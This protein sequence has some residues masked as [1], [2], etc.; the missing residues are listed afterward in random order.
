[1]QNYTPTPAPLPA[2]I[3][4]PQDAFDDVVVSTLRTSTEPIADAVAF[5]QA[6]RICFAYM[7]EAMSPVANDDPMPIALSASFPSGAWAIATNQITVPVTGVYRVSLKCEATNG[8][9]GVNAIANF[10]IMVGAAGEVAW[11]TGD[12]YTAA[13]TDPFLAIGQGTVVITD[14]AAHYIWVKNTSGNYANVSGDG[15]S[16]DAMI[17]PL[18]IEYVG[19][20]T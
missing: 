19:E 6:A 2:T 3:S 9:A 20:S 16:Q 17:N 12:R 14:T 7:T 8:T 13:N 15:S 10:R 4:L 18:I 5:R 11:A 1:M